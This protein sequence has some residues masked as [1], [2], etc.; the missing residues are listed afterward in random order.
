MGWAWE[1]ISHRS[2]PILFEVIENGE[3]SSKRVSLEFDAWES[4]QNEASAECRITIITINNDKKRIELDTYYASTDQTTIK[5]LRIDPEM[6]SFEMFPFP[7]AP[8][9]PLKFTAT[10]EGLK[11]SHSYH[12]YK[13]KAVGLWTGLFEKN[14]LV[15]IEWRQVPSIKLPY[16]TIGK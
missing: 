1:P 6:V 12:S 8:D 5:N 13:A 14:K 11:E 9:R 2:D 7:M 10:L 4:V 3:I 15:N 16:A